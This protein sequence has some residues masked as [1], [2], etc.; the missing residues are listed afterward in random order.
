MNDTIAK[1]LAERAFAANPYIRGTQLAAAV[2]GPRHCRQMSA[3]LLTTNPSALLSITA[4]WQLI[5]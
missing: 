4:A 2:A 3:A 1:V 5:K